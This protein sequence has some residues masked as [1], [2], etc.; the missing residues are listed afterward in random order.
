MA[1][2]R[3]KVWIR[4]RLLYSDLNAEFNNI[5]NNALSLIS[6][7]TGDL[8]AGGNKVTGLSSGSSSS[9][10]LQVGGTTT[11][12]YSSAANTLDVASGGSRAVSFGASASAVNYLVITSSIAGAA[13]EIDATGSDTNIGLILKTKGIGSH[14]FYF[15]AAQAMR[16]DY[17]GSKPTITVTGVDTGTDGGYLVL[18]HDSASP[19]NGDNCGVIQFDAKD[20]SNT[21][22]IIGQLY[23]VQD[24]ITTGSQDSS[25]QFAV[26]NAVN[27]GNVNTIASLSSLGVWT[28]AVCHADLKEYV[29]DVSDVT[30]KMRELKTLGKYRRSN[31]SVSKQATAE[32]H[33]GPTVDEFYA[34]F[35]IGSNPVKWGYAA[36]DVA[37]L[38]VKIGLELDARLTSIETR[39]EALEKK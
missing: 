22:R 36:A 16:I 8:N 39:L 12:V 26:Q 21:R 2:S 18:Y 29:G 4:E 33:Y 13:P 25:L 20:A 7:L 1:L 27:A 5:L 6:P 31:L 35:A 34:T 24:D 38:A 19:A 15:D 28:N 9:P 3:L 37:W 14:N 23:A 10:S 11:G 17:D 32:T 30:A